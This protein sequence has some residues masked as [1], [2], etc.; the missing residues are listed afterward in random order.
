[1]QAKACSH[2]ACRSLLDEMNGALRVP[3][4]PKDWLDNAHDLRRARTQ[5]LTLTFFA[6]DHLMMVHD[7]P[8]GLGMIAEEKAE[9]E[10]EAAQ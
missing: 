7:G 5:D 2:C 1:M 10:R 4:L 9:G 6:V 3:G 8:V